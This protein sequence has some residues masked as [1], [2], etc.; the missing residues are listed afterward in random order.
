MIHSSPISITEL[1]LSFSKVNGFDETTQDIRNA[2]FCFDNLI[3]TTSS[4]KCRLCGDRPDVLIFDGNAKLRNNI[5][6]ADGIN[7]E[8]EDGF[9]GQVDLNQFW[10]DNCANVLM[11]M[12]G[13]TAEPKVDFKLAPIMDASLAT[14]RIVNTEYMK[15][16]SLKD[17]AQSG[18]KN[19]PSDE[20]RY[21]C[22][23][24]LKKSD[25]QAVCRSYGIIYSEALSIADLRDLLISH[26]EGSNVSSEGQ[27]EY[28]QEMRK[29]FP[30]Y[31]TTNGGIL[32]GLCE[33]GIVYYAKY[34]VR[35][36]GARDILDA[37]LSFKHKPSYVIYD[38]AGRLA[39]HIEKRLG[40]LESNE[41]IGPFRGRVIDETPESIEYAE[42]IKKYERT[43]IIESAAPGKTL[44]LYDR[45]HQENSSNPNAVLRHINLVDRLKGI[46]SELAEQLNQRVK[47]LTRTLNI[48]RP[49]MMLNCLRRFISQLNEKRNSD[50][51][52]RIAKQN[53]DINP[54]LNSINSNT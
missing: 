19:I 53:R 32:F 6:A 17:I 51:D 21:L 35:G 43:F 25:L 30:S 34:L 46:N 42:L 4:F 11:R 13:S 20:I 7:K 14:E 54:S 26:G 45:F 18:H 39:L 38:D 41:M 15:M 9:S 27:P 5:D 48:V 16:N 8:V 3:E 37:L 36:E 44:I 50:F 52:K 28:S 1:W 22:A 24:Y 31:K 49:R 23:K 2:F 12:F 29:L 47:S 40:L 33:H 10:E